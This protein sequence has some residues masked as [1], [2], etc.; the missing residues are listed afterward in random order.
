MMARQVRILE[1]PAGGYTAS[2][3]NM[4]SRALPHDKTGACKGTIFR[5]AAIIMATRS[6]ILVAAVPC[7]KAALSSDRG[8]QSPG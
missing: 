5:I 2:T 6:K 1:N 8:Q 3:E 4:N 7:V